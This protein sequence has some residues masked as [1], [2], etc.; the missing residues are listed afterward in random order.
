MRCF[1]SSS[2]STSTIRHPKNTLHLLENWAIL[3]NK[4]LFTILDDFLIVNQYGYGSIFSINN[5]IITSL[6]TCLLSILPSFSDRDHH[7]PSLTSLLTINHQHF[8]INFTITSP[9]TSTNAIPARG[10]VTVGTGLGIAATSCILEHLV[11]QSSALAMEGDG[12]WK[13][14][15]F[16]IMTSYQ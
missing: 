9:S 8:P 1:P 4:K 10:A 6:L 5:G 13:L 15:Y 14:N 3:A 12:E 11:C 7:W 2:L 16:V